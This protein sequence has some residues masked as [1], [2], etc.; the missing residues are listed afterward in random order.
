[1]LKESQGH[2]RFEHVHFRYPSRP[3]VR[4]LR[5]LDREIQPGTF[6]AL[7]GASGCGKS[8]TIQLI[9]CFYDPLA[10]RVLLDEQD[11]SQAAGYPAS[12]SSCDVP[13]PTPR[14]PPVFPS[15]THTHIKRL[16]L[17]LQFTYHS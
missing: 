8:T 4:V 6:V 17:P 2:I 11:I 9:E 3:G 1:M 16:P 13:L 7:V 10:G 15:I 14:I 5:D 12:Q